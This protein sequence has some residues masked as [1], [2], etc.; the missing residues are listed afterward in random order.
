MPRIDMRDYW[1]FPLAWFNDILGCPCLWSGQIDMIGAIRENRQVGLASAHGLGK[2]Y[3]VAGMALCW[4]MTHRPS[5]VIIA[6]PTIRQ[7]KSQIWCDLLKM[8]ENARV[9][10]GPRPLETEIRCDRDWFAQIVALS[11]PKAFSG[12]HSPNLFMVFDEGSGVP[13]DVWVERTGAMTGESVR[14]VSMENPGVP[15][16]PFGKFYFGLPEQARKK[17][18]AFDYLK[19]AGQTGMSI[20]GCV[21]EEW[22]DMMRQFE[23]TP[24][25]NSKVLGEFSDEDEDLMAVPYRWLTSCIECLDVDYTHWDKSLGVDVARY[26]S[27]ETVFAPRFGPVLDKMTIRRKQDLMETA[28][29]VALLADEMMRQSWLAST[30]KELHGRWGQE[31]LDGRSLALNIDSVGMGAGVLDRLRELGYNA[32][33][34]KGG[35]RPEEPKR[36]ASLNAELYWNVRLLAETTWR[37]KREGR[38]Q[39]YAMSIPNDLVL[40]GQLSSRRYSVRS[41][42]QIDLEHKDVLRARGG[43]SPDRGDAAVYAFH[44]SGRVR[45]NQEKAYADDK[46]YSSPGS[47]QSEGSKRWRSRDSEEEADE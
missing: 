13:D 34:I 15:S 10:F 43:K 23:G 45:L 17:F 32:R 4:L 18:S 19:W 20:P 39:D 42:K 8:Y 2:T 46:S 5:K 21:T 35:D 33:E 31:G 9:D 38:P 29:D 11:K 14:F 16:D 1:T 3:V 6:S 24:I 7:S 27:D 41:D 12:I 30:P 25:W 28:G 36:Y 22:L 37:A 40:V 47:T 44:R 26:G